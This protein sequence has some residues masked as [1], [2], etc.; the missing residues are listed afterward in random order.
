M[1]VEERVGWAVEPEDPAALADAV[2]DAYARRAELPAFRER[3]RCL[4]ARR[5]SVQRA[6][7]QWQ[8]LVGELRSR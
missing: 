8:R 3:A 7:G 4:Y 5:F 6:V 1:V 2:R